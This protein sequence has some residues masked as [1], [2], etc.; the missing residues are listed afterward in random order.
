MQEVDLQ[1]VGRLD[2]S[3]IKMDWTPSLICT[4][5]SEG[6]GV[7]PMAAAMQGCCRSK[8]HRATIASW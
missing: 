7:L 4:V 1:R 5:E 2:L 8:I 3:C 6:Y